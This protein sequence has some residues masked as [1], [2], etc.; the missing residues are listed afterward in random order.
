MKTEEELFT[1]TTP[2][3]AD[4]VEW[5]PV[6]GYY[7]VMAGGTYQ[8][9]DPKEGKPEERVG[10]VQLYR[11]EH[12]P[13]KKVDLRKTGCLE[14]AAVLDMKWCPG[15]F[16]GRPTIGVADAAGSLT[17]YSLAEDG[18]SLREVETNKVEGK[19]ALALSLSWDES[20]GT[21]DVAASYSD[22]SLQLIDAGTFQSKQQW[23]AHDLE[24]WIVLINRH[25]PD[26]LYSGGDDCL[27]Q[28]WDLRNSSSEP[29]FKFKRHDAGVCSAHCHPNKSH[30]IATGGYDDCVKIWDTRARRSPLSE[31]HVGGGVWRLKWR[32]DD[33]EE[34]LAACMYNGVSVLDGSDVEKGEV[35][36]RFEA[37]KSIAY[38]V[39]WKRGV[40]DDGF[41]IASC[42][43][44]DNKLSLWKHSS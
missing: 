13:D 36:S 30:V 14:T 15:L 21:R 6:T 37:H 18:E 25:Q 27:L 4:S 22:G 19:D 26:V 24:A 2:Q 17:L 8:L 28:C 10:Q 5:C 11:L 35:T 9:V 32:P 31:T 12:G 1:L 33:G 42:S 34:L 44:Y 39:D 16:R 3:C 38:G 7:D 23:K 43:F 40:F 29:A 41:L 20:G